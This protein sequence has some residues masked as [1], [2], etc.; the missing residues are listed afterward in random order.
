M[1][2]IMSKTTLNRGLPYGLCFYLFAFLIT[3]AALEAGIEQ[4]TKNKVAEDQK[5]RV[6]VELNMATAPEQLK[7]EY[8]GTELNRQRIAHLRKLLLDWLHNRDIE[9]VHQFKTI[10][11][12]SLIASESDIHKL[13]NTGLIKTARRVKSYDTQLFESTRVIGADV[14]WSRGYTGLGQTVAVLDSGVDN[15]HAH[16]SANIV[17][18]A[19]FL[20][21]VANFDW[22]FEFVE[23][24][25][26]QLRDFLLER[27]D[28]LFKCANGTGEQIGWGASQPCESEVGV[29]G[30]DHGTHVTG[31]V[32]GK[33]YLVGG[34]ALSAGV[35]PIRVTEP[36]LAHQTATLLAFQQQTVE[37][38]V[39]RALEWLYENRIRLNLAA[40]NMSFGEVVSGQGDCPG[41]QPYEAL[42]Q[43]LKSAGVVTIAS[44]G[45]DSSDKLRSPACLP[46]VVSVGATYLEDQVWPQGNINRSLDLLAPGAGHVGA[47]RGPTTCAITDH[48]QHWGICSAAPD[49]NNPSTNGRQEM[50]TSMAAPHVAGAWAVVKSQYPNVSVNAWLAHVKRTATPITVEDSL[51]SYTVP[52][53]NLDVATSCPDPIICPILLEAAAGF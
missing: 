2:A 25:G 34:V 16:F 23:P 48:S 43:Q 52:R 14:A 18:E 5:R 17:E 13:K 3:P 42:I 9:V 35:V 37:D 21:G 22:V 15:D 8:S 24:S 29:T 27:E 47:S 32:A 41:S 39:L 7:I 33:S 53:L 36:R 1:V 45:N 40:V 10:P 44:S 28:S 11:Y 50:G 38:N 31:I 30:C 4:D 49:A 6:L 20:S 51:G 26:D 12:V 19:C 46:D